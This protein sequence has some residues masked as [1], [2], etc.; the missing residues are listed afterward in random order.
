MC[1]L[2]FKLHVWRPGR[3]T[4][5]LSHGLAFIL[6]LMCVLPLQGKVIDLKCEG[7]TAPLGI[8]TTTP[9]FSWK[10]VLTHNRECQTAY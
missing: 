4:T 1:N 5:R 7:L 10:H 8:D 9:H 2:E 6:C 3:I